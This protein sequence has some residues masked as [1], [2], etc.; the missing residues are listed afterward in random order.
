MSIVLQEKR[1]LNHIET[2]RYKIY[3]EGECYRES[4]PHK[5]QKYI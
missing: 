5:S 2:I 3:L 4:I 1:N